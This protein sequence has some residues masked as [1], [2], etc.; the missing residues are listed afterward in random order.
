[1][2]LT[3]HWPEVTKHLIAL[4]LSW[5]ALSILLGLFYAFDA[6]ETSKEVSASMAIPYFLKVTAFTFLIGLLVLG[7]PLLIWKILNGNSISNK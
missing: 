1:M 2:K 4:V 5:G 3:S 6:M 7:L